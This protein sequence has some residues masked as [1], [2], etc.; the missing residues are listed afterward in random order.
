ME[1]FISSG[2]ASAG[3][4]RQTVPVRHPRKPVGIIDT[5]PSPS[6]ST[7]LNNSEDH[8]CRRGADAGRRAAFLI[9]FLR[10]SGMLQRPLGNEAERAA[11]Y[12]LRFTV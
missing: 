6:R 1:Q 7:H 8:G 5:C 9:D 2:D 10:L 3:S 4:K 11:I 12:D